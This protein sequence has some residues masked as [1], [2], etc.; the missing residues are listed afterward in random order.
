M[1]RIRRLE[2]ILILAIFTACTPKQQEIPVQAILPTATPAV[3]SIVGRVVDMDGA[4]VGGAKISS[5]TAV[6][7]SANDGWFTLAGAGF[8]EWVTV[9]RVGYISRVRAAAPGTP[10]LFRL[11]PD[12]GKTVVLQ[13]AGDTMFGRRFFDPNEDG[14][15][16][17]GL[18]PIQPSVQDHLN[19]IAP[20]QPLLQ[21]ADLTV[22]NFESPLSSQ[23]F[24]S[25]RDPRPLVYH[26]TKDY[27]YASHPNS[28]EALKETG[29]DAVSIGNNHLY[30]ILE[31]GLADT[32][33]SLDQIG[34]P[35]FG[36]GPDET[37]AWMPLILT[38]K[39][40]KIAFLSCT[41]IWMPDPPVTAHD[42][43]YTASDAAGKGGAAHCEMDMVR[44]SVRAAKAQADIVVFMIH[45]GFEYVSDPSNNIV[46]L[47]EAARLAGANLVINHHPHVI[48][49]F[50][51]KADSL[52]AWTLGNFIFDQTVWPTFES[53]ILS[54][55][56]RDGQVV[57]AYVEPTMVENYIAH[58]LTG[59]LTDPVLRKA[60]GLAVGPYVIESDAMEVDMGNRA[61]SRTRSES[62]QGNDPSGQIIPIPVGQWLTDFTGPGT[63]TLGRDLLW[64]GGFEDTDVDMNTN[65]VPFWE[66][67]SVDLKVGKEYAYQGNAG[68]RLTRG[69]S[70]VSDAVTTHL[71][72]M[73]VDG[74][75]KMSITGMVRASA[76]ASVILQVS[77][78]PDTKGPSSLQFT[79]PIL[80]AKP[81]E[82]E[83]F[84]FDVQ[85]PPDAVAMGIY[86]RLVP[87]PAGLVHAD[88]DNL[89]AIAWA[90]PDAAFGPLY[91][92]A[93]VT[94]T[95]E[96]TF[97]QQ[98]LPGAESWFTIP[99]NNP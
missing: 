50:S 44:S 80:I 27:V 97:T 52:T 36:G 54:V 56:I 88:F 6:T 24:F 49:G 57:R 30:D 84:R 16:S 93:L 60:A 34:M 47:S 10:V 96:L 21:N 70:N 28:I 2:L 26:S 38:A 48:G 40:Q 20:I 85:A 23:P 42:V 68:L 90:A 98:L 9:Q 65:E 3:E 39:E 1:L 58:G 67:T 17:D 86:L 79:Q 69:S 61:V 53:Y 63:V 29:I 83:P 89:R 45:G 55:F 15:P 72:R 94:D 92:F 19:L 74:D 12:D 11:F 76:G 18:L 73:L 77:W 78:Y 71:H 43:T 64:I 14:D 37:A 59:D 87:P 4:P 25:P 8:P 91:D 33:T 41:T 35:Y 46:N 62:V 95:G 66:L 22:V 75:T 32:I 81:E 7:L 51:W 31:I 99:A 5:D 82:W 13:F